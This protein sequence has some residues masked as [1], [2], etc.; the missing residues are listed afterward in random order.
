MSSSHATDVDPSALEAGTP[1]RKSPWSWYLR[2]PAVGT[3]AY[4]R[5]NHALACLGEFV[6]VRLPFPHL[7]PPVGSRP[8]S[9]ALTSPPTGPACRRSSSSSLPLVLHS[10]SAVAERVPRSR[11][12]GLTSPRTLRSQ[13]GEPGGDERHGRDHTG[14]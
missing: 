2:P 9:R 10:T 11:L 5:K 14:C 1:R 8:C 3:S 4:A 7:R 6:G 12:E 13:G